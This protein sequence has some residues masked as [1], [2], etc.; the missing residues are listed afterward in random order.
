MEF[1]GERDAA[2]DIIGADHPEQPCRLQGVAHQ[3]AQGVGAVTGGLTD[4]SPPPDGN[5]YLDHDQRNTLSA[6]VEGDLPWRSFGALTVNYGSGF[7]NGDGPDH[8]PGYTTIDLSLGK[9]FG[10]NFT[11][12][13]SGTNIFNVRYQL[14]NS[15]TFGGTH[16]GDPAMVSV[17]VRYRFH[18]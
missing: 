17:Q 7:L 6:G 5:F 15:N 3:I 4:F 1:H 13:V 9:S 12:R 14:D 10:E 8:L 2:K 16:W 11:V 18:Y